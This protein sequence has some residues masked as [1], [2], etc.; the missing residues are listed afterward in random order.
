MRR[1]ARAL[2]LVVCVLGISLPA[3]GQQGPWLRTSDTVY[4]RIDL[5]G[6][7]KIVFV[8]DREGGNFTSATLWTTSSQGLVAALPSSIR[9]PRSIEQ[10]RRAVS[11]PTANW[12]PVRS[13]GNPVEPR[14]AQAYVNLDTIDRVLLEPAQAT[15]AIAGFPSMGPIVLGQ[16]TGSA[17]EKVRRTLLSN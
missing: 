17:L 2:V 8:R 1:I 7:A 12:V 9:D 13:E 14:L 3:Y 4:S 11:T 16:A 10:L 5:K 6:M 15:L